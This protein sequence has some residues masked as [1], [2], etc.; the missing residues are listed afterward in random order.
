MTSKLKDEIIRLYVKEEY[1][2]RKICQE[3]N[4]Q[5]FEVWDILKNIEDEF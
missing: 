4:L 2:C 5:Y 3:L 1:T